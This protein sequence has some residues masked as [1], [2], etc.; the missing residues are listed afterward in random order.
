MIF[1]LLSENARR[2]FSLVLNKDVD[3]FD[4]EHLAEL[5]VSQDGGSELFERHLEGEDGVGGERVNMGNV[6]GL[7]CSWLHLLKL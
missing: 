2:K 7:P 1:F 6:K 4:C 3:D 5:L